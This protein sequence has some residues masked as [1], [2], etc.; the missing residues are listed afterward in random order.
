MKMLTR[1]E[2]EGFIEKYI[3]EKALAKYYTAPFGDRFGL[4]P[5]GSYAVG[6]SIGMEID[7]DERPHV[8]VK[9]PG[10]GNID[11]T[12]WLEGWTHE[13]EDREIIVDETGEK[14]DFEEAIRRCCQDGDVNDALEG[15]KEQLLN[16]YVEYLRGLRAS[17]IGTGVGEEKK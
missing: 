14:I 10:T 8:T 16:D 7:P 9:V 4:Y 2:M 15:L 12:F 6:Q 1:E 11:T 13:G 17:G 5:D 3:D